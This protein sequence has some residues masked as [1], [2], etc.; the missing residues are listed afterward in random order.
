MTGKA[1]IEQALSLLNYTDGNG[2][3][4]S[5]ANAD[6]MLRSLPLVNQIYADLWYMNSKATFPPLKHADENLRL[7][8]YTC[9]NIMPYGVAMLI[10][11]SEGDADNQAVYASIYNQRRGATAKKM[12]CVQDAFPKP[13]L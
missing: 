13:Y 9:W 1:I 3:L 5:A 6:V 8:E 10:A 7:D 11:Q 12:D 2:Q 4:N